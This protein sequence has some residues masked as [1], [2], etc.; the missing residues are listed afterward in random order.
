MNESEIRR[1]IK[2]AIREEL[3]PVLMA[4][5]T[6]N[7]TQ[8]RSS[9]K[10]FATAGE[11][12]NLRS[13]QP[14]GFGSRAPVQTPA[15][16]IP[17][18]GDPT[19]L[20]IAGHFDANRP[21]HNNGETVL[22]DNFGHIVYL[23][24][25]KMQ[26]GSKASAENMVLGQVFKTMMDTLLEAIAT[27]THTGNLGYPTSPPVNAGDFESIKASP[28]DDNAILSDKAFTEK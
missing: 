27:H 8:L 7:A 14:F 9:V 13:I 21:S 26:F 28:I 2:D 3:A 25:T 20:V 15:L 16:V 18:A 24:S 11:I 17:I 4:F 22:Y 23:S 1:L 19:H 10:N 6:A 12:S 5:V